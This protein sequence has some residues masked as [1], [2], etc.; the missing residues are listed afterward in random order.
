MQR[1]ALTTLAAGFCVL[2][3][4]SPVEARTI[5][6]T[7][8]VSWLN[9][10]CPSAYL[11]RFPQVQLAPAE[12]LDN[13][14]LQLSAYMYTSASITPDDAFPVY[15]TVWYSVGLQVTGPGIPEKLQCHTEDFDLLGNL[16]LS[17][18]IW[19]SPLDGYMDL[20][21]AD[22]SPQADYAAY[23]GAG[24]VDIVLTHT[25]DSDVC[26]ASGARIQCRSDLNFDLV[27]TYHTA[28]V[29]EPATLLTLLPGVLGVLGVRRHRR[30]G[31]PAA[32]K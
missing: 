18:F 24:F 2:L 10:G 3:S 5:V 7:P 11:Y 32:L 19:E 9:S 12:V 6:P 17:G 23:I 1:A 28:A 15:S 22:V 27:L 21:T 20:G 14:Q 26:E 31:N 4:F 8:V 29:P 25:Q 13:V 30:R 16:D